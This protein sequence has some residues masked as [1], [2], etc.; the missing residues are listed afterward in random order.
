MG[1]GKVTASVI[2]LRKTK[3]MV[4]EMA[5]LQYITLRENSELM[6]QA[7]QWFHS[8]WG[9]PTEA[10]LACMEAYGLVSLPGR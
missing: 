5:E 6:N 9:V 4:P 10:Y 7:A 1:D 3:R 8:K 2:E